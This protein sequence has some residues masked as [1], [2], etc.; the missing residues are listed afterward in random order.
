MCGDTYIAKAKAIDTA[1]ETETDTDTN[2]DTDTDAD[3]DKY[4]ALT[5]AEKYI[6][7]GSL[8]FWVCFV[9]CFSFLNCCESICEF[10]SLTTFVLCPFVDA[11]KMA[12]TLSS[13]RRWRWR[14]RQMLLLSQ[15][16]ELSAWLAHM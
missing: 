12:D 2:T 7:L 15:F 8:F 10:H 4:L 9:W 13:T 3:T 1:R 5:H 11:L 16:C 6:V 14:W